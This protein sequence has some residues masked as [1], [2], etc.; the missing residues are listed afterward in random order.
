MNKRFILLVGV[1]MALIGF[2]CATNNNF[3]RESLISQDELNAL[4]NG[5]YDKHQSS[6]ILDGAQTYVVNEGDSMIKISTKYYGPDYTYI[7]PIIMVASRDIV[8]DPLLIEPGM[9]LTIPVLKENIDP[10]NRMQISF[11]YKRSFWH[12]FQKRR[13]PYP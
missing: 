1:L 8:T 10:K 6:V 4:F 7:F 11:L 13:S 2:S 3:A 12:I 5:V 9:K